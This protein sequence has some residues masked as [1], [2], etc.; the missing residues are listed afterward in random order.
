MEVQVEYVTE[1]ARMNSNSTIDISF[2]SS[3]FARL[4]MENLMKNFT[5]EKIRKDCGL[6][7]ILNI[8]PE[9]RSL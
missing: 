4:F 9:E 6:H 7:L 8:P 5:K 2:P 3:D 1:I